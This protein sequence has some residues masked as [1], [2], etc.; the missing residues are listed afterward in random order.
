METSYPFGFRRKTLARPFEIV[1]ETRRTGGKLSHDQ[2]CFFAKNSAEG[3]RTLLVL[4]ECK[5]LD[6]FSEL[7]KELKALDIEGNASCK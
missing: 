2:V 5:R 6:S 3:S 7:E 1:I 4:Q